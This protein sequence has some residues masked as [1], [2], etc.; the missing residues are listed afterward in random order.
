MPPEG[1]EFNEHISVAEDIFVEVSHGPTLMDNNI[2]LLIVVKVVLT[3]SI[4]V[5]RR[6]VFQS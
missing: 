2:F 6:I 4:H 3:A 1:T 5:K